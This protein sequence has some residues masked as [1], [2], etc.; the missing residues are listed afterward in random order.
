MNALQQRVDIDNASNSEV[1]RFLKDQV[2]DKGIC[3]GC[4]ACIA[5]LGGKMTVSND[6]VFPVFSHID[7]SK[8]YA[9]VAYL[10]C[11]GIGIHYPS[12]YRSHYGKIPDSWLLGEVVKTR[13][14]YSSNEA[15]REN[16]A[17]GGVISQTLSYLLKNNYSGH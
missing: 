12:L 7:S 5:L 9:R 8:D 10:A 13:V 1:A 4:G 17:S 6:G 2:V 16:G 3:V 14:G 15:V 11:P